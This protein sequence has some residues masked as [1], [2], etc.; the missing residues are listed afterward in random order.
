MRNATVVGTAAPSAPAQAILT[1]DALAFVT[2]LHTRFDARRRELLAAR[3]TRQAAFDAGALPEFLPETQA[4]RNGHWEVAPPPADLRRRWVEITGPV[5]RKMMINALNSGADCF[6]ADFEDAHSPT[7]AGT[8]AGQLNVRDAVRGQLTFTSSEGKSYAVNP[9]PAVLLVRPRGWHLPERHLDVHGQPAS[10]SLT[11]AGLFLFHNARAL[12]DKGSGPYLYLPKLEHHQEAQ[13]WDD[14]LAHAEATLG[15]PANSIRVTV[16]IETLPAAFQMEEILHALRGRIVGLNAGRWD[17]LFSTIKTLRGHPG[18]ILPDRAALT[19]ST[20]FLRSY[21]KL[22]VATCHKR[23][24]HAMGGMAAFI[25]NRRDPE[26]TERALRKVREDK[27]REAAEGFDGTWVAHPDLVPVAQAAFDGVLHGDDNQVGR[28]ATLV[29]DAPGLLDLRVPGAGVT[30]TGVQHN[31]RAA[32]LYVESWLR[33]IGAVAIDN[34]MEDAAT[35]EISRTQLW[36]WVHGHARLDDGRTVDLALVHALLGQE[37]TR[38]LPGLPADNRL[39]D[40]AAILHDLVAAP[41][42]A[43]FLTLPAYERLDD[44]ALP[45]P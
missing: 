29:R 25:P 33:G 40:A 19:M 13:L 23:G 42:L 18:S 28:K 12:L 15:L 4:I 8:L 32:L 34:L 2:D 36:S 27:E 45:S 21:A 9:T 38:A 30:E 10:A 6:M 35:A 24:A 22:L 37:R 14:V 43:D 5:E 44:P 3:R 17:Y 11:D 31:V 41:T 7:W 26:V 16:L 39:A 1:P 20:P